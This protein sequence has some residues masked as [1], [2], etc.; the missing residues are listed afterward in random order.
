[1]PRNADL[2]RVGLIVNQHTY[3]VKVHRNPPRC[4]ANYYEGGGVEILTRLLDAD[5][6]VWC[7]RCW[8]EEYQKEQ[9]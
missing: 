6:T 5:A 1:M 9:T 8:P 7:R 2:Y 3:P 4:G